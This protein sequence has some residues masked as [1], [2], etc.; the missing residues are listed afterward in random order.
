M[1]KLVAF[2]CDGVLFDSR[3]A[4]IAFYNTILAN[5][6]RPPMSEEAVDYVHSHTFHQSLEHL[7][8]E[9]AE[10]DK[11]LDFVRTFD[12]QPFIPMMLEEPYLRE[13]LKFLRPRVKTAVA[14][15]RTTT[16]RPVLIHHNL[17]DYFDVVVSALDVSRPKPH[18]ES[19]WVILDRLAVKP[20]EA[21]YI[22]DS[23]VDEEFARNAGVP[24]VAY[25]QP[26]LNAVYYLNSFAEAP[27]LIESL[28]SQTAKE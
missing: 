15:N 26:S 6:G 14:T 16:T 7:F 19:F 18:P 1:L 10:L 11:V 12:Y 13:F 21:I 9:P 2:D 22:G 27:A 28:L 20:E 25:R 3:G 4:N 8:R 17:W 23:L 24:L 5:F